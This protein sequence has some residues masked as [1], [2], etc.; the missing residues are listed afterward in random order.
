MMSDTLL[1]PQILSRVLPNV[2]PLTLAPHL[3]VSHLVVHGAHLQHQV[4]V[5]HSA[6]GYVPVFLF[7]H[8]HA[9]HAT[10]PT[11]CA[12]LRFF[13]SFP[14]HFLDPLV[15]PTAPARAGVSPAFLA[16]ALSHSALIVP[17]PH[18]CTSY[19]TMPPHQRLRALAPLAVHAS[20][21]PP[22]R[23]RTAETLRCSG[24][25]CC[26]CHRWGILHL[27]PTA[28]CPNLAYAACAADCPRTHGMLARTGSCLSAPVVLMLISRTAPD[29]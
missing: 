19:S 22:T 7:P 16:T 24:V 12:L 4:C 13:P 23:P 8:H 10:L 29:E 20:P 27:P 3:L 15:L 1:K 6:S 9:L 25:A 2:C 18:P 26:A 28:Q 5:I 11:R 21:S 14:L 17:S